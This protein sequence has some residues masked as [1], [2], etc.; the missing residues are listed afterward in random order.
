MVAT[1]T[2][3]DRLLERLLASKHSKVKKWWSSNQASKMISRRTGRI[4]SWG[5]N[6]QRFK[7]QAEGRRKEVIK[8]DATSCDENRAHNK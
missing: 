6:D 4:Q 1:Y 7:E 3:E 8:S 5:A 2:E